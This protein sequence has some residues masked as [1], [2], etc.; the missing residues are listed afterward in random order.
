MMRGVRRGG[1]REEE[2]RGHGT[3]LDD[4][5]GSVSGAIDETHH[6]KD[7]SEGKTRGDVEG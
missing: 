6:N 5:I 3:M 2:G 4:V 7:R 1:R